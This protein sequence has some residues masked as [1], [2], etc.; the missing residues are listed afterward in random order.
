MS[1]MRSHSDSNKL[2]IVIGLD[3]TL[4]VSPMVLEMAI[5]NYMNAMFEKSVEDMSLSMAC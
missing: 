5:Q 3:D 4:S 1:S 2:E